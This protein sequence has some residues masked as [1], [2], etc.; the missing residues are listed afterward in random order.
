MSIAVR[1]GDIIA[2]LG[3]INLLNEESLRKI[4]YLKAQEL[5]LQRDG[6]LWY[7]EPQAQQEAFHRSIAKIRFI[8]GGNRSGKSITAHSEVMKLSLGKHEVRK[9][10]PVPNHGWIVSVDYNASR[11]ISEKILDE[12]MPRSEIRG[13]NK[14]DRVIILR[15]KSTIGFKSCDSGRVKFQGTSRHWILFDEEP[16]YDIYQECLMRTMDTRG[17]IIG[18]LTPTNGF[19][20][21]YDEI[22][23]KAGIDKNIEVFFFRTYDNK[24]LDPEEIGRLKEMINPEEREMRLEGKFIQLSGLVFKEYDKEIH[25][26]KGFDIPNDKYRWSKFRGIDHGTNN[27]TACIW[28]ACNRDGDWYIYD[29]YYEKDKTIKENCDAIQTISGGDRYEWTA[30]D[31]STQAV[32]SVDKKSYYQEYKKYGIYAKPIYLNEVN[33]RLAINDIR[34]LLRVN[35]KTNK[36]RLYVFD[37]CHAFLSEFSRYRWKTHKTLDDHNA[38]EKPQGYMDHAITALEFIVLSKAG[39]RGLDQEKAPEIV[40]WY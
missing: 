33:I 11:D 36:P 19:S 32:N 21:V 24:Y 7:Y 16:P 20:W 14:L 4:A 39:Y 23:E 29:E 3:D 31:G 40:K 30:I 18:A 5:R 15:N 25:V 8:F 6:K 38:P 34:S 13:Y 12:Y 37:H 22:Y 17:L 10:F 9:K 26:I 27:P 2:G 1:T 35:E 28:V